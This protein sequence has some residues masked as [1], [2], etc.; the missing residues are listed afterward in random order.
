MVSRL[1]QKTLLH[2]LCHSENSGQRVCSLFVH[3]RKFVF[4]SLKTCLKTRKTSPISKNCIHAVAKLL[5]GNNGKSIGGLL[6]R[7]CWYLLGQLFD[8]IMQQF[9]FTCPNDR[10]IVELLSH[11]NPKFPLRLSFHCKV[12][13]LFQRSFFVVELKQK[14]EFDDRVGGKICFYGANPTELFFTL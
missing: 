1:L 5:L 6:K 3:I 10:G 4:T 2:M 7:F 13:R 12:R 11:Y 8:L 14:H 9:L